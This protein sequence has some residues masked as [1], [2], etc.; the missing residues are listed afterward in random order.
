MALKA[1]DR[2]AWGRAELAAHLLGKGADPQIVEGV[3]DRLTQVGLI[4]DTQFAAQWVESRHRVRGLP[5]QRLAM[6]LR[7][8]GIDEEVIAEALAPIDRQAEA[9]AA[10]ELAR[11]KARAMA[12]VDHD[13]ALRRL[14]GV[15][16]RRGFSADL[17]WSSAK[18][19]LANADDDHRTQ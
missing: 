18:Q 17:A 6:E 19:A 7:R 10:M 2:R 15:L 16:A 8:K 1:L 9:K 11:S 14:V 3:L 5:A 13:K 12:G 4:S